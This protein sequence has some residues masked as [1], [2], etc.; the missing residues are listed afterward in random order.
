MT[1]THQNMNTLYAYKIATA[2]TQQIITHA[3]LPTYSKC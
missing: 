1:F 2:Q 3:K